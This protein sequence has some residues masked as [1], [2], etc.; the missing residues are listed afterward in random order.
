MMEEIQVG[1]RQATHGSSRTTALACSRSAAAKTVRMAPALPSPEAASVQMW[2]CVL[3][4]PRSSTQATEVSDN[5]CRMSAV[6]SFEPVSAVMMTD[7]ARGKRDAS[8]RLDI[9]TASAIVAALLSV[10]RPSTISTWPTAIRPCS[11]LS[12]S[13]RWTTDPPIGSEAEATRAGSTHSQR[14]LNQ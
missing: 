5:V 6:P 8:V 1:V 7:R 13:R 12:S 3:S 14:S 2:C 4:A 10:G 11:N 9:F